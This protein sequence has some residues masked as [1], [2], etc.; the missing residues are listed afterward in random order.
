MSGECCESTLTAFSYVSKSWQNVLASGASGSY[1]LGGAQLL[2][3]PVSVP[4]VTLSIHPLPSSLTAGHL[5]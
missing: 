1:L 2:P 3:G 4:F 5:S